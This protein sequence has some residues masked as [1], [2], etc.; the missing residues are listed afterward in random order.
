MSSE[1]SQG[2]QGSVTLLSIQI[3]FNVLSRLKVTNLLFRLFVSWIHFEKNTFV[4]LTQNSVRSNK[5]KH[6][7]LRLFHFLLYVNNLQEQDSISLLH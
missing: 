7:I 5:N 1:T 2:G 3:V 4:N 6:F